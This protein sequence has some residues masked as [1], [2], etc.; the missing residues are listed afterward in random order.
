M[1]DL[2]SPLPPGLPPAGWYSDGT[3]LRWWDGATWG[4]YAPPQP[5]GNSTSSLLPV[6]SH[7]GFFVGG[8][9]LTLVLRLT[10][11]KKD[12][13]LRHH[14]TEALNFQITYTIL[15]VLG[16]VT[17]FT[18]AVIGS[19][20]SDSGDASGWFFFPFFLL[21]PVLFIPFAVGAVVG[22]IRAGQGKYWRYPISIRFVRGARGKNATGES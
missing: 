8:F 17:A 12:E 19:S 5:G 11:G 15:Y 20:S 1:S 22:A 4:P 7:L 14:G 6:L 10:E 13:Y 21:F 3:G 2:A 9:I 18:T 16:M